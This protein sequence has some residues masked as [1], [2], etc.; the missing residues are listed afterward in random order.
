MGER[1]ASAVQR[2]QSVRVKRLGAE[3]SN[4]RSGDSA[5]TSNK[6][7]AKLETHKDPAASSLDPLAAGST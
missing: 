3:S 1:G 2:E 5:P 4:Q 7:G 6:P